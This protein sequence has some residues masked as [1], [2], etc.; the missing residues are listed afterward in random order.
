M[1]VSPSTAIASQLPYPAIAMYQV[2]EEVIGNR[3]V[4]QG[5]TE[6]AQLLIMWSGMPK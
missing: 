1:V 5:D 6:V 3:L 2:L 4:K